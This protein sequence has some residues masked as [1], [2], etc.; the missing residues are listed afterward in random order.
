MQ[1]K[2]KYGFN[3]DVLL[4][5]IRVREDIIQSEIQRLAKVMIAPSDAV[6]RFLKACDSEPINETQPA[7]QLLRRPKITLKD[8]WELAPPDSPISFEAAEQVEIRVKYNGYIERQQRDIDR[9]K[10]AEN[11]IIP[12]GLD[13]EGI[14]GLPRESKDQLKA[15]RPVNFGQASRVIGVRAA[16]IAVLHI[17]V[18][19]YHQQGGDG[20]GSTAA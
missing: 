15:I 1:S 13:Y 5:Q 18:E 10:R 12:S 17:Y 16:D 8:V 7:D 3:N 11:K 4:E 9:F 6:N 2:A 20:T 19:K 14:P